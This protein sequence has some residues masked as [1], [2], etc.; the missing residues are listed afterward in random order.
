M[1]TTPTPG[2][3][4][5]S[6]S[7]KSAVSSTGP[8]CLLAIRRRRCDDRDTMDDELSPSEAATRIG[9]TTRTVQRWIVSGQLPARRV[10]GRWR[11]A[12]VALD[13]F[14]APRRW[15]GDRGEPPDSGRLPD[16]D[17][18]HRESR[19]DRRPDP[20]DVRATRDPR[21]GS[22]HGWR[23]RPRPARH[24]RGRRGGTHGRR[25][26]RPSRAS[27]SSPRTRTSPKPS[28]LPGCV[29]WVPP[30]AAIRAMGDKAAARALATRLGVPILP[31]YDGADQ[32]D[33]D[34]H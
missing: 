8:D 34:T 7:A 28:R 27:A 22:R 31:G 10:G 15:P 32:T 24:R 12:S 13:V 17:P 18:V 29:G 26:C 14:M 16:P 21:C 9:T 23:R 19:R 6:T 25:R 3:A 2:S 20:A 33:D 5:V 11:V 4:P 1:G 30:P